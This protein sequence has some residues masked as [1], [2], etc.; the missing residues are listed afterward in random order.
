MDA[1]TK[2]TVTLLLRQIGEDDDGAEEQLFELVYADL[3]RQAE[4]FVSGQPTSPRLESTDLVH[5]VYARLFV[6]DAGGGRAAATSS[7]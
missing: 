2:S 5:E 3:H 1:K 6:A 4:R 7:G